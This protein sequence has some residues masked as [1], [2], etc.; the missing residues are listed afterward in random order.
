MTLWATVFVSNTNQESTI[1]ST[2]WAYYNLNPLEWIISQGKMGVKSVN[3]HGNGNIQIYSL[4]SNKIGFNSDLYDIGWNY[5]WYSLGSS[6]WDFM[7]FVNFKSPAKTSSVS[8]NQF[9]TKGKIA[10]GGR[11]ANDGQIENG[12]Q[13]IIHSVRISSSSMNQFQII[14]SWLRPTNTDAVLCDYFIT[15]FDDLGTGVGGKFMNIMFDYNGH[16]HYFNAS[17]SHS[18]DV[19]DGLESSAGHLN[20]IENVSL[21]HFLT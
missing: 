8:S 1:M 20:Y 9:R 12:F 19:T 7:G 5:L 3:A 14:S 18:V 21:Q 15:M 10:V 4:N 11:L 16:S 17:I 13:G 6:Q 2:L